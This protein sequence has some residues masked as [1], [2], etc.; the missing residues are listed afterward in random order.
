MKKLLIL[1]ATFVLIIGAFFAFI[2]FSNQNAYTDV[3]LAQVQEK[4]DNK[5]DFVL[6]VYS[7]T[8]SYCT[9]FKP[10]LNGIINDNN[11]TVYAIDSSKTE[12]R[13][14]V[15]LKDGTPA[16]IVYEDGVETSR[17]VGYKDNDTTVKFLKKD[18]TFLGI[19]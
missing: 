19:Q 11:V 8:C 7:P 9:K 15:M 16:L 12:N 6:Y 2:F 18:A 3:S 1:L 14:D 10:V 5:E 13:D 17:Q 4:I